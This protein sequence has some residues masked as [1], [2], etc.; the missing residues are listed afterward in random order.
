MD[1]ANSPNKLL[2]DP[3]KRLSFYENKM[4]VQPQKKKL[5]SELALKELHHKNTKCPSKNIFRTHLLLNYY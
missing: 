4:K 3:I 1:I 5:Y 2:I